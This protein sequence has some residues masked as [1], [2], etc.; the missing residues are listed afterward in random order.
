MRPDQREYT[1]IA[2]KYI[3]L[4][5]EGNISEILNKQNTDSLLLLNTVT[6]EQANGRYAPDKWSLKT[7]IGHIADVE[8]LWSY[9][10]FRIARGDAREFAGY[11]R[12]IF[13]EM[14]ACDQL[15]FNMVLQ[16]YTA[17]RN[18]TVSL[19]NN[20]SD[21]AMLRTGEFS[22]HKLSARA[23]AY[24]IAGHETHHLNII[25]SKYLAIE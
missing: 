22:D 5:T 7:V 14:S 10:L 11:D 19:I 4:V 3:D 16:D 15:P 20:L 12:D 8:R 13:A 23:C 21:E 9:R 1:P 17:V 24:V 6:E 2:Q 18:A 25:K